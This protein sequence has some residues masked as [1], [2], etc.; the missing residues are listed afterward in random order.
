MYNTRISGEIQLHSLRGSP[1]LKYPNWVFPAARFA[2]PACV[3]WSLRTCLCVIRVAS[4]AKMHA[5][6]TARVDQKPA[7]G[8]EPG[9][10]TIGRRVGELARRDDRRNPGLF[11]PDGLRN[12]FLK[13]CQVCENN[14]VDDVRR[15]VHPAPRQSPPYM[16]CRATKLPFMDLSMFQEP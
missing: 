12:M 15:L 2:I 6:I 5:T 4:T 10:R 16:C 13:V 3:V 7:I 8:G 11:I 14:V 1:G 9:E